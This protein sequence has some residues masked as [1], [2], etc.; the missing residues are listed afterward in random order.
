MIS[1]GISGLEPAEYESLHPLL[2]VS[3]LDLPT[4]LSWSN[5]HKKQL[6]RCIR[7][8]HQLIGSFSSAWLC[9]SHESSHETDEEKITILGELQE[10]LQIHALIIRLQPRHLNQSLTN[11]QSLPIFSDCPQGT[12]DY[13]MPEHRRNL[14]LV[15]DPCWDADKPRSSM[16]GQPWIA[17]IHG[18]HPDR[19]VRR[20]GTEQIRECA[21]TIRGSLK[22]ASTPGYLLIAHSQRRQQWEEF[23]NACEA[24]CQDLGTF[25]S[26]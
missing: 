23:K 11:L 18:W 6:Q 13:P 8:G 19:W 2:K 12:R 21:Q 4:Y 24:V 1:I 3:E 10:S 20:Y 22:T 14:G 16:T 25:S 7:E 15:W 17:K 26:Y 9:Q 5:K